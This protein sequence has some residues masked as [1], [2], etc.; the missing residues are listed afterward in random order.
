M[1]DIVHGIDHRGHA[2]YREEERGLGPDCPGRGKR[3]RE[4]EIRERQE[5]VTEK[6]MRVVGSRRP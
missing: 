4:E 1:C 6:E 3:S 5:T 2:A